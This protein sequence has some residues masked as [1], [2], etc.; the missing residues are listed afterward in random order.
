M[1]FYHATRNQQSARPDIRDEKLL[2]LVIL[3]S[4]EHIFV[5]SSIQNNKNNFKYYNQITQ[6]T[7]TEN[8]AMS[9][10]TE[11]HVN[12]NYKHDEAVYQRSLI[13]DILYRL[14]LSVLKDNAGQADCPSQM[15][16]SD[17]L[18]FTHTHRTDC[19][20]S[21]T[22]QSL[23]TLQAA[24]SSITGKFGSGLSSYNIQKSGVLEKGAAGTEDGRTEDLTLGYD[25]ETADES[26][27]EFLERLRGV[28]KSWQTEA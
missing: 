14:R 15:F 23:T 16:V 26:W 24:T 1:T 6:T 25:S 18:S 7:A 3:Q 11:P 10:D 12:L 5:I 20:E 4:I 22:F 28:G 2:S 13:P 27:T 17:L 19:E 8:L 21:K 9:Q